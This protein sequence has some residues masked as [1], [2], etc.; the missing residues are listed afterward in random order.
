MSL[1]LNLFFLLNSLAGQSK[2]FDALIVFLTAYLPYFLGLIF[3][4]ALFSWGYSRRE[5]IRIFLVVFLSAAIARLGVTELIR[6]FYN[7]PRP[8][9]I[10]QAH[11]L[12]SESGWSFPSGHSAFFFAMSTVLYF[13][14]KKW[15]IVF[16]VASILMNVGRI[17][18]G[19]HYPSDIIGGAIIG[20]AVGWLVFALSEKRR[21]SHAEDE[22]HR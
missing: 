12:I 15:G 4:L 16:F 5:K 3:L 19:V 21:V 18:A 9:M 22:I 8:F 17:I 10:Y 2:I 11:Q 13:Y 14:N 7:R 1:D 6:Y 20:I